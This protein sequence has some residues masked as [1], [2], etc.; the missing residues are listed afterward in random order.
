MTP[1]PELW[2]LAAAPHMPSVRATTI[3]SMPEDPQV[4]P[5]GYVVVDVKHL[6]DAEIRELAPK[7]IAAMRAGSAAARERRHRTGLM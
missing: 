5:V 7:I 6:T 1:D 3:T 2:F 4:E